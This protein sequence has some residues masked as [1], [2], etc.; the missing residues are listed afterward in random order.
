VKVAKPRQ[1]MRFD[2]P[3]IGLKTVRRLVEAGGRV[4]AVEAHRT[5]LVDEADTIQY[6]DRHRL[7][8]V[9]VQAA[10]LPSARNPAAA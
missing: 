1:D 4:L 2:V 8:I 10:D 7:T 6:A 5:I 9:A 3:T